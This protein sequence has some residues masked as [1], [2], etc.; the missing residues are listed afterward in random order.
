[1]YIDD[2]T[3]IYKH[4]FS[5]Y[6]ITVS[7]INRS[8]SDLRM[9]NPVADSDQL[10][11]SQ[12]LALSTLTSVTDQEPSAAISLLKRSEWNVQVAQPMISQ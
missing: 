5:C 7:R 9:A 1:M 6:P 4:S 3:Y 11:E 8:L 2:T 12:Q 10:S